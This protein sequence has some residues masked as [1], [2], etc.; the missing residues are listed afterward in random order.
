MGFTGCTVVPIPISDVNTPKK[1]SPQLPQKGALIAPS[2]HYSADIQKPPTPAIR[3]DVA[4]GFVTWY[5]IADHGAKTASGQIYDLY[6][7]T[8]ASASLPLNTQV[9]VK[10]L[11][12]NR[13]IVV[14]VND[15][16]Y[17]DRILIKLSYWG[18][19]RLGLVKRPSQKVEVRVIR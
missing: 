17:D 18:A 10:N 8:A 16:L 14:T 12:T 4:R 1:V 11:K 3:H 15:R 19:R 7:M 2:P 9:N 5:G 6:G 13:S